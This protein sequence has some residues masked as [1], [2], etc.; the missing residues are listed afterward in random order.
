VAPV[1]M[2]G[3]LV[4]TGMPLRSMVESKSLMMCVSEDR[5]AAA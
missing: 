4:S 2:T 5:M 1:I 3:L